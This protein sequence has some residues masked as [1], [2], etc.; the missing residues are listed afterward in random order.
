MVLIS[1]LFFLA[2]F[3]SLSLSHSLLHL[4]SRSLPSTSFGVLVLLHYLTSLTQSFVGQVHC[5]DVKNVL[6][7]HLLR[8]T[9]LQTVNDNCMLVFVILSLCVCHSFLFARF[10]CLTLTYNFD[11]LSIVCCSI[12]RN[13]F[14]ARIFSFSVAV[15]ASFC[16][17]CCSS[18]FVC[19]QL[20]WYMPSFCQSAS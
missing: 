5:T 20:E 8:L 11:A 10:V 2:P 9:S 17:C 16:C 1:P 7:I 15:F 4:S 19:F 18:F 13:Q 6:L 12:N 14:F 3:L